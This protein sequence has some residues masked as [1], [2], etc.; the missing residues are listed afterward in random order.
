[1]KYMHKKDEDFLIPY[2][3]F[4]YD[5]ERYVLVDR[6]ADAPKPAKPKKSKP[7]VEVPAEPLQLDEPEDDFDFE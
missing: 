2:D 7:A 5:A 4:L 6:S 3:E 1:M